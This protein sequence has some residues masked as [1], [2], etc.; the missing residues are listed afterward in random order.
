[1]TIAIGPAQLVMV[2]ADNGRGLNPGFE[3]NRDGSLG[4]QIVSTLVREDLKGQFAL[5]NGQGVRA[6]VT[7]PKVKQKLASV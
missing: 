5:Y 4:L 3:L 7:F 2:I 6:Q 1:M